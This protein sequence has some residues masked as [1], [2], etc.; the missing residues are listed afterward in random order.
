MGILTINLKHAVA[1]IM[2]VMMAAGI[3]SLPAVADEVAKLDQ[4][5]AEL[6]Q[7]ESA[8]AR[9]IANEIDLELSKSGSPA[10]DLLLKRGEDA[11]DSGDLPAAI[12]HLTALTDHA[13][14]FAEGWY[15]RSLAYTHSGLYGPALAD[16]ERALALR[17][18][19]FRAIFGL[20]VILEELDQPKKALEAYRKVEALHPNYE[21]LGAFIDRVVRQL[22]GEN[23]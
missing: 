9:K 4:L 7:A 17:P 23:I 18:R 5:F 16:L 15:A 11:L 8:Q 1:A 20:G 12:G 13:P 6:G 10:M 19:H 22:G 14:D 2:P 21:D 3:F